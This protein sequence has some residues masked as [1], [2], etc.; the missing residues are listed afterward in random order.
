MAIETPISKELSGSLM[1]ANLAATV[2]VV[3]MHYKTNDALPVSSYAAWNYHFQEFFFVGLAS[4]AVPFFAFASGFFM[5]RKLVSESKR[6]LVVQKAK[7]LLVPYL[8]CSTIIYA[9]NLVVLRFFPVQEWR[10][11]GIVGEIR[12]AYV[13]P[14]TIQFWYLRDLMVATA[15]APLLLYGR[16]AFRVP[17]GLALAALWVL[18]IQPFPIVA[19]YYV[20]NVE[21]L[22]FFWLGGAAY[23][24]RGAIER[25]A[26]ERRARLLLFP[27][28]WLALVAARIAV[29]PDINIWYAREATP[30]S[31]VLHKAGIAAG[32]PSL[33]VVGSFLRNKAAVARLS[34]YTFF[35]Y[36]FHFI[37]L[38]YFV[39]A[40]ERIMELQYIC[41]CTIPVALAAT[42][43]AAAALA[44]AAPGFYAL[45]TGG[46]TPEKARRR[47]GA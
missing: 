37:P 31:L 40:F 19:G 4:A 14:I 38:F 32:V 47:T 27:A 5:R 8:L 11:D 43:G 22:F 16:N 7:T 21:V 10:F 24:L 36:A 41:Y 6:T 26:A 25:A 15:A 28:V 23:G 9:L 29:D 2:L 1:A 12:K 46:R 3:A 45:M 42:F 39:A 20:L 34:S 35:V 13:E 17:F 33:I 18:E 30:L 44:K